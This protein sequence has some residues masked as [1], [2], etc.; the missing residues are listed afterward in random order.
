VNEQQLRTQFYMA[1][2]WLKKKCDQ[3]GWKA[4][5]NFLREYVRCCFHAKFPN[6][7]SPRILRAVVQEH[8]ELKSF[9]KIGTLKKR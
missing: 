7:V 4:S 6:T 8:P 2:M 5:S 1:A 9:I 3:D